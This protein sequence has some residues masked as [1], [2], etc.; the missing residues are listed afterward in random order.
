[1]QVGRPVDE[2]A[3]EGEK[4]DNFWEACPSAEDSNLEEAM[5][6]VMPSP[7]SIRRGEAEENKCVSILSRTHPERSTSRVESK[8]KSGE[9]RDHSAEAAERWVDAVVSLK[10]GSR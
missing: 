7:W 10:N 2:D 8:G 1:M 4:V 6:E 9:G 3:D 5:G